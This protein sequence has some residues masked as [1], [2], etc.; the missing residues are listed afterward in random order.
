MKTHA[1]VETGQLGLP[2]FK[3]EAKDKPKKPR[4]VHRLRP[5]WPNDQ[6]GFL[7]V[8]NNRDQ[9]PRAQQSDVGHDWTV[10]KHVLH[11]PTDKEKRQELADKATF[12][13]LALREAGINIPGPVSPKALRAFNAQSTH[14]ETDP[15]STEAV[16]IYSS[17]RA[18]IEHR[19]K[20]RLKD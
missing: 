3:A 7:Q 8:M 10:K 1:T 2:N 16:T 9:L 18:M 20:D 19:L 12:R 15:T 5:V 11:I 17:P 4:K 13:V 6:Q 14:F